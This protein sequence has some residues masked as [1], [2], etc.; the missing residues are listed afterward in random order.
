MKCCATLLIGWL[1][2]VLAVLGDLRRAAGLQTTAD[3]HGGGHPRSSA[4]AHPQKVR[5]T[6]PEPE[7]TSTYL[8]LLLFIYEFSPLNI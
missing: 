7:S 1:F 5:L 2:C 6:F 4:L 8:S 3:R